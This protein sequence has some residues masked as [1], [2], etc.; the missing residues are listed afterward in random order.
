MEFLLRILKV[1]F[2]PPNKKVPNIKGQKK[3][4]QAES[5]GPPLAFKI[6][7]I[8]FPKPEPKRKNP[9]AGKKP[10]M[11]FIFLKDKFVKKH[12]PK[13]ENSKAVLKAEDP[14]ADESV[15]DMTK[16]TAAA[17]LSSEAI[18]FNAEIKTHLVPISLFI[19]LNKLLGAFILVSILFLTILI[20]E[21]ISLY[22]L[23]E[24]QYNYAEIIGPEHNF[25]NVIHTRHI[26]NE[27]L[28][29]SLIR[30][31]VVE[32]EQIT[33]NP[34]KIVEKFSSPEVYG[35]YF[36][37]LKTISQN[38][39]RFKLRR[40]IKILRYQKIEHNI[41]Q[42]EVEFTDLLKK[43]GQEDALVVKSTWL[44]NIKFDFLDTL[45]KYGE[46]AINPSGLMVSIYNIKRL[47]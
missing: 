44:I 46:V 19:K 37:I 27:K 41:R 13:N 23:V 5:G 45:R 40:H 33:Q 29:E 47:T 30:K 14:P 4:G 17:D 39:I 21:H 20:A 25:V 12:H 42:L 3:A 15:I 6:L 24:T 11:S 22:P 32:R 10:I 36:E 2:P 9:T 26:E 18:F 1:L 16:T 38:D 31:Y 35:Q 43:K 7:R 34:S 28:I 8:L